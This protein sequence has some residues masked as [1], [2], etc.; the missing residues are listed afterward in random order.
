MKSQLS[1]WLLVFLWAAFIF[2]LSH[3]PDL[4]SELSGSWDF[5][6]R[7][8]A[9][10]GE[11]AVLTLLLARALKGNQLTKKKVLLLAFILA[12]GYAFSDEYHQKFV[13]GRVSALTDVLIDSLGVFSVIGWLG[14]KNLV[15][16]KKSGKI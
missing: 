7:K 1:K 11:Y 9:H 6:L 12:V 3:Q 14:Y 15:D 10:F 4:K 16:K 5:F 2:F 8:M 13:P